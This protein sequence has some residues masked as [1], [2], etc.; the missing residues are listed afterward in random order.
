MTFYVQNFCF[1]R[2]KNFIQT[3]NGMHMNVTISNG[4]A[5]TSRSRADLGT[6][7]T[8]PLHSK[9]GKVPSRVFCVHNKTH[10]ESHLCIHGS[11]P[12]SYALAIQILNHR[13]GVSVC[14]RLTLIR[15]LHQMTSHEKKN[16][17]ISLMKK[18][19]KFIVAQNVSVMRM[20]RAMGCSLHSTWC[21]GT[22][23]Y[24]QT[25]QPNIMKDEMNYCTR[26]QK[27]IIQNFC[28]VPFA[29]ALRRCAPKNVRIHRQRRHHRRVQST[30]SIF[31][32]NFQ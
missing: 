17:K 32:A 27:N 10:A 1:V 20:L 3:C 29:C 25:L 9:C 23:A 2:S 7:D 19:G 24:N 15:A 6:S 13:N 21:V 5:R 28:L 12:I 30:S 8:T 26:Q 11:W 14:S 22:G 18:R 4:W 31:Y 16:I